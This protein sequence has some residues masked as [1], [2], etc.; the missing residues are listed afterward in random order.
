MKNFLK[1]LSV[2]IISIVLIVSVVIPL[3]VFAN[4]QSLTV[5]FGSGSVS[6]NTITYNVDGSNVSISVNNNYSINNNTLNID[7]D[8]FLDALTVSGFDASTMALRIYSNDGF[9][10]LLSV[11]SNGKVTRN[12]E[13][14]YPNSFNITIEK[15]QN[16]EEHGGFGDS[17]FNGSVYFVWNCAGKL[18]KKRLENLAGGSGI[19]GRLVFPVNYIEENEVVDGNN[20]LDISSLNNEDYYFVWENKYDEINNMTNYS[21]ISSYINTLDEDEKRD[22]IIDPTGARDGNSVINT[23][24]DR[25]FRAAIYSDSFEG[26]TFGVDESDYTY[27]LN[28][29]DPTFINSTVD[30]SKTTK[31]KPAVYETYMLEPLL[32]FTTADNS[33]SEIKSIKALDINDNAVTINKVDGEFSIKFNSNYYSSVVFELT[34][35]SNNKYYLK[36]NRIVMDIRHS[37]MESKEANDD[38]VN[39]IARLI[40]PN[41]KHY[42]DYDVYATVTYNDNTTKTMKVDVSNKYN[43][44]IDGSPTTDYEFEGGKNL[45]NASYVLKVTSNMKCVDFNV[46]NKGALTSSS[47]GGTFAGSNKGIHYD[48]EKLVNDFYNGVGQ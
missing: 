23:N 27:F 18:C 40:Y 30:I 7:S 47:Y 17:R 3:T 24:G 32:K 8:D 4:G 26:I 39:L 44:L 2:G 16:N 20:S 11:D 13:G 9:S 48:I 38:Y 12:S 6:N 19:D 41:N 42:T 33:K 36:V 21:D 1:R 25:A 45:L 28:D 10:T 34:D 31:S 15:M 37:Y 22:F 5:G 29:W 35:N 46:L 43:R 14:G